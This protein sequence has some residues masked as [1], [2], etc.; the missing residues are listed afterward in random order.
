MKMQYLSLPP[1]L[2]LLLLALSSS[3]KQICYVKPDN[4]S[5]VTCPGHN[6]SC[7]TL[8]Q[9]TQQTTYQCF[10]TGSTLL[11]LRGN[12][13]LHS[14]VQ[15]ENVSD[16]LFSGEEVK[17][18]VRISETGLAIHCENVTNLQIEGITFLVLNS[19]RNLTLFLT[20]INSRDVLLYNLTFQGGK[21]VN[22]SN[23]NVSI[24]RCL[25]KENTG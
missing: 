23:S 22:C 17:G 2:A 11:F 8:D 9:Y 3:T 10:S 20:I 7:L 24:V 19:K 21:T 16:I 13:T 15:L 1:A 12:H 14:K 18:D 6:E 25:F 4:N 5:S